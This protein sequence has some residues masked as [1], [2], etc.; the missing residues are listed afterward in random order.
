MSGRA[1]RGQPHGPRVSSPSPILPSGARRRLSPGLPSR[2]LC[3]WLRGLVPAYRL[4][5]LGLLLVVKLAEAA[6]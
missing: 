6:R 1:S 5:L 4:W 2:R 3:R